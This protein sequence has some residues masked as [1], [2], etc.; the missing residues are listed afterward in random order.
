MTEVVVSLV[1]LLD[2]YTM[3][4]HPYFFKCKR[5]KEEAPFGHKWL[6]SIPRLV[7]RSP[8]LILSISSHLGLYSI[9]LYQN[10]TSYE[11][12]KPCPT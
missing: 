2:R 4:H 7:A 9:K 11:L 5:Q 6:V 10:A 1:P 12:T 8:D 3:Y